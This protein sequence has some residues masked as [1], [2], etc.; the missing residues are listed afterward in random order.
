LQAVGIKQLHP[1]GAVVLRGNYPAIAGNGTAYAVAGLLHPLHQPGRQQVHLADGTVA[2][3]H[4]GIAGITRKHHRGMG[5]ITQALHPRQRLCVAVVDNLHA[6]TGTFDHHAKV[7][8]AAQRRTGTGGQSQA[9]Q[10][11]QQ[12]G[13]RAPPCCKS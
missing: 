9:Q 12:A 13:Q 10:R 11:C 4:I 6:A 5:Q 7:A 8:R 1:A 2:A 3:K